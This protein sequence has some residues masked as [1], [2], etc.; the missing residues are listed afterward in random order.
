MA[1]FTIQHLQ[2]IEIANSYWFASWPTTYIT[3]LLTTNH[4]SQQQFV[5]KF[6]DQ[7]FSSF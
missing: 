1:Q 2:T 3:I 7:V 6:V 4:S 5:K